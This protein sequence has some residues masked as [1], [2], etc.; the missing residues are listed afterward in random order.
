[1]QAGDGI[2][3]RRGSSA[4]IARVLPAQY[5]LRFVDCE[6][7]QQPPMSALLHLIAQQQRVLLVFRSRVADLQRACCGNAKNKVA[8][9]WNCRVG[10]YQLQ[11][12]AVRFNC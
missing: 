11:T 6:C 8:F 7:S 2:A 4:H 9:D 1:M 5:P 10:D 3:G 12:R